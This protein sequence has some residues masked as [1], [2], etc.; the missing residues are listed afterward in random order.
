MRL[1]LM[2]RPKGLLIARACKLVQLSRSTFYDAQGRNYK[3]MET[4]SQIE[5]VCE[6]FPCYG[7]RRTTHQLKA[8]GISVGFKRVRKA[9]RRM[10]LLAK[11]R[12]PR[13][14][15]TVPV[16][17]DAQNLL[18]EYEPQKDQ[19]IFVADATWLP[20]GS[21]GQGLYLAVVLDLFTRRALGYKFDVTLDSK[22]TVN[23]LAMAVKKQLPEQNWIHH[24]DRGATYAS[25]AYRQCI[26]AVGGRSSFTAPG[27]PTQNGAMES[28]FKTLK[29][30]E[31]YRNEYTTPQELIEGVLQ[32]MEFY[33]HTR[34]HSS[35]GYKAPNQFA[36][37]KQIAI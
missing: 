30:E 6:E 11:R 20:F 27:S 35:L 1:V 2:H 24:S 32:Y 37:E 3:H 5:R 23:A 17:V 22:L 31:I 18:L 28:F 21:K 12:F 26:A 7:Y 19:T 16:P 36:R 9:M 13:R 10:G 8:Q 14:R 33:N 15:T 29:H 4:D 25:E 34:L